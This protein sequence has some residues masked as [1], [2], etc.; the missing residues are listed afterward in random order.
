MNDM[1]KRRENEEE[2]TATQYG[3]FAGQSITTT[4]GEGFTIDQLSSTSVSGNSGL[5]WTYDGTTIGGSGSTDQVLS[6][7]G[8]WQTAPTWTGTTT[9]GNILAEASKEEL[10]KII[11]N[12]EV[13]IEINGEMKTCMLADL[14]NTGYLTLKSL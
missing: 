2:S 9:F 6:G 1:G 11:K 14:L 5:T 3:N 10:Q 8:T 4:S 7:N 12:Q 13:Q